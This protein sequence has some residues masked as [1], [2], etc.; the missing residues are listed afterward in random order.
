MCEEERRQ[1]MG[2]NIVPA[3]PKVN[4]HDARNLP[5]EDNTV[6]MVFVD[7]PYS[8][9]EKY[10]D[11]PDD[12]GKISCE[13]S[14]FFDEL[15]KVAQE[16]CRVLKPGKVFAWLIGDQWVRKRFT[17]VGLIL[18]DRLCKYFDP[19]DIICIARR[20]QSSNTGVWHYRARKFNFF[21]RGFK[22]LLIMKKPGGDVRKHYEPVKW[23]FYQR[24]LEAK[25]TEQKVAENG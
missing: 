24:D 19:V 1:V 25:R 18:Y 12:I 13:D 16:A 9:N 8:D 11:H 7:S 10:N 21:L 14:R 2:Y 3:H 6:D 22:Y 23:V 17:P 5:L 4:Q 15:E 20:S